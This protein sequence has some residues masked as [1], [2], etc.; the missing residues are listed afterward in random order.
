MSCQSSRLLTGSE[1]TRPENG[2]FEIFEMRI[3]RLSLDRHNEKPRVSAT[4]VW[5]DCDRPKQEI[6][7]A[8]EDEF[9]QH[10][11][12]NPDAFLVAAVM[13]ALWH[14][15][16]RIHVDDEICPELREGLTTAMSMIRSWYGLERELVQIE[17][18]T[19]SSIAP[20]SQASAGFFFSGGVDSLATL[21]LNRLSF[22]TSHPGSI[23]D[24][25]IVY[26]LEV[27]EPSAFQHVLNSLSVI[28]EDARVALVPVY[29]NERSLDDD[30]DFWRDVF[31]GAVF[32]ALAHAF[33]HRVAS[34]SIASSYDIPNLNPIGTHPL[35]DPCFSSYEVRIKHDATAFSR[36]EKIKLLAAWDVAINN[37]RVCNKPELYEAGKLNCG[38]C[39]K[40]TRTMLAMLAVGALERSEAF[41]SV[42]MSEEFVQETVDLSRKNYRYYPELVSALEERGRYDL[43]RCIR[44]KLIQYHRGGDWRH[45]IAQVKRTVF[46]FDRDHLNGSLRRLKQFVHGSPSAGGL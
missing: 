19:R 14:G 17:A 36:L 33:R 23:K 32:G 35:L 16:R 27:N 29:T 9:A 34:V 40:C 41:P 26:G 15:E 43:A 10:F 4:V 8:T 44:R 38:K 6:Y 2:L 45:K 21:R 5:E 24:G 30:W 1:H 31:Q 28:A 22:P 39:E 37:L 3:D 13:P 25:L 46:E 18:G 42:K 11:Y 12:P 7:F 20:R